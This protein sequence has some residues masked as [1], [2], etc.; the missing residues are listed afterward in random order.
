MIGAVLFAGALLLLGCQSVP[1]SSAKSASDPPGSAS[2]EDCPKSE[3]KVGPGDELN[4]FVFNE[5]DLSGPVPVRPDGFISMPLIDR[6]P[7]SGKTPTELSR[8]IEQ[9]LKEY[10]RAPQV[11]VIVTRFVGTLDEQIRVVGQG[12]DKPVALPYRHGTKVMDVVIQAG[13]LAPYASLNRAR[14]ERRAPDGKPQEIRVR[15]GDLINR[16]DQRQ[17]VPMCPGDVL[18]IPQSMF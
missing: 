3:Y 2:A 6:I 18:V 17:N 4:I 11:N 15:L 5:K 7:A 8:D 14:I 12:I 10:V 1:T 9:K 13:T 16:G